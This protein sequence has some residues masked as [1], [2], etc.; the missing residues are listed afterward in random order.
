MVLGC[1]RKVACR[2]RKPGKKVENVET[3]ERRAKRAYEEVETF[4]TFFPGLR[5]RH[6][7]FLE[8]PKTM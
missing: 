3:S 2:V 1:K 5:T 7:A 6:A 4:S 8:H